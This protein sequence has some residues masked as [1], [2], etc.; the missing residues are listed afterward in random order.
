MQRVILDTDG[1]VD[2]ALAIL[3]LLDA[4]AVS[5]DAITTVHGNV[6]VDIATRNVFEVLRVGRYIAPLTIA[7]GCDAPVCAP[8]TLAA[9][10]HGDDG[11]GGWTT[12]KNLRASTVVDLPAPQLIL[13]RARRHPRE[14]TLISIGPLTNAA[15]ALRTDPDAFRALKN[16]VI[17]G[18]SVGFPGN[19]TPTAE[20]NIYSD[21][22]AAHDVLKSA[23]P[24]TLVGLNGTM[25]VGVTPRM[26]NQDLESRD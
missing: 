11:L 16:V 4:P 26:L 1:G 20:Y 24:I 14:I 25:Q 22:E 10:V 6:P 3:Y 13:D 12:G 2:D 9:H 8:P 7:R 15:I 23:V 17:M 18:G 21:P 19:V 5:I